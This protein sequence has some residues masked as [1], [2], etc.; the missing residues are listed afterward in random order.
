MSPTPPPFFS[1]SSP[2][3][4]DEDK[5]NHSTPENVSSSSTIPA[6]P[7]QNLNIPQSPPIPSVLETPEDEW[8][9]LPPKPRFAHINLVA[10]LV[11]VSFWV[12]CVILA[13]FQELPQFPTISWLPSS[14]ALRIIAWV[15][16]IGA[17]I[18]AVGMTIAV[19]LH[20]RSRL[21]E[22]IAE[23]Y[24]FELPKHALFVLSLEDI[25][26]INMFSPSKYYRSEDVVFESP[27][28]VHK[29]AV[30]VD[31]QGDSVLLDFNT[32]TPMKPLWEMYESYVFNSFAKDLWRE[33]N[34]VTYTAFTVAPKGQNTAFVILVWSDN[35]L[36]KEWL[37]EALEVGLIN[38]E[39]LQE[40]YILEGTINDLYA[41]YDW[42]LEEYED[43]RER[44]L[45]FGI[46]WD[47]VG[48]G[49]LLPKNK[50]NDLITTGVWDGK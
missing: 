22:W 30:V 47:E 45:V 25:K 50:L 9:Y 14:E 33:K 17:I 7:N 46:N 13:M 31:E 16:L 12:T 39:Q 32:G 40:N 23:T 18:W 5:Q 10:T 38:E 43:C 21:N 48:R 44:G 11:S 8:T 34:R 3:N 36:L 41:Q 35:S 19:G 29:L 20:N 4:P 6:T 24:G 2:L 27:E 49:F 26:L 42:M 37:N 15:V 1:N 28:G